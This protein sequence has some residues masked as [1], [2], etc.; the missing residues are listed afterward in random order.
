MDEL[1]T[2]VYPFWLIDEIRKTWSKPSLAGRIRVD[3]LEQ[4]I[5]FVEEG[6]FLIYAPYVPAVSRDPK[7]DPFL[8]C[9]QGADCDY[10][11]TGDLDL[12]TLKTYG[13]T[14]I[15]TPAEFVITLRQL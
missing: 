8:A 13:R 4:L 11:V 6:G 2:V 1:F 15:V 7:D 3:D 5:G 14:H 10:L 12:L 9:V